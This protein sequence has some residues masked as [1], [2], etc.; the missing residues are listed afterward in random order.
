MLCLPTVL[1]TT[2]HPYTVTHIFSTPPP[3]NL[4][5]TSTTTFAYTY[6]LTLLLT[7]LLTGE[8]DLFSSSHDYPEED[9]TAFGRQDGLFSGSG[10][11]FDD[12][13]EVGEG[14]E[15]RERGGSG[16]KHSDFEASIKSTRSGEPVVLSCDLTCA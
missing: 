3:H 6:P 10:T 7:L 11:L 16:S 12:V 2:T 9:G 13:E 1:H 15:G 8:D 4:T 14:E 5:H